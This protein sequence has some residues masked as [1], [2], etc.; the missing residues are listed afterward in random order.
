MSEVVIGEFEVVA[1]GAPPAAP[2]PAAASGPAATASVSAHDL[3]LIE[4]D[5]AMR[6][7]R[8]WAD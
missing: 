1:D 8:V 3:A 6:A 5:L 4:R 7:L 2:T